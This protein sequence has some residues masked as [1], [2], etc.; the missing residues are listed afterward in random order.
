[1]K[2]TRQQERVAARQAKATAREAARAAKLMEKAAKGPARATG[3][4]LY[5]QE[6]YQ[7]VMDKEGPT[8]TLAAMNRLLATGW[9]EVTCLAR[10]AL[11]ARRLG[12]PRPTV[13]PL[14]CTVG[15]R[16]EGRLH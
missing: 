12:S 10:P 3:Y 2:A 7:L 13:D 5:C 14:A 9:K 11:H 16:R 8:P 4:S 1:M 6:Q 15:C